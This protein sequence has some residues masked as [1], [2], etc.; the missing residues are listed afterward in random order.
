VTYAVYWPIFGMRRMWYAKRIYAPRTYHHIR[1]FIANIR[2][3]RKY[4]YVRIPYIY[5][6]AN[7]T[8]VCLEQN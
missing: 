1:H 5:A 2:C 4:T 8:I 3:K 6:R 7:L